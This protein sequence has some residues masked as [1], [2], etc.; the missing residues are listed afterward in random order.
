MRSTPTICTSSLVH[1]QPQNCQSCGKI[2]MCAIVPLKMHEN[3]KFFR[4]NIFD[5]LDKTW[6]QNWILNHIIITLN[7]FRFT[8]SISW[9]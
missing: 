1:F 3:K 7:F 2:L 5:L 9:K 8:I 4:Y 6:E